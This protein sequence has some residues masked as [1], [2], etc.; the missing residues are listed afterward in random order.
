MSFTK[1]LQIKKDEIKSFLREISLEKMPEPLKSSVEYSLFGDG[2]RIRPILFVEC[3]RMFGGKVN[4]SVKKLACALECVHTYS[5]IHDDLPCMDNDDLRRGKPTNHKVFGESIAVLAGDALLNFAYE[6]IFEAIKFSNYDIKFIDAGK[7]IADNIGGFGLIA[8]QT[9]D[10]T[11]EKD[12]MTADKIDYIYKHKTSDL[13]KASMVAGA[14]IAGAE[15]KDLEKLA[16]YADAFGFA[17][18]IKDDLLDCEAGQCGSNNDYVAVYGEKLAKTALSEN[19]DKAVNAL[20]ELSC[21][22]EF[23]KKLALKSAVRKQ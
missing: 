19:I 22:T 14:I 1:E 11:A 8:G 13:I 12:V 6:L 15:R 5:L 10:M 4:E 2:K 23:L 17:F 16:E 7:T 21:N 9:L 3:F 20:S 18:Q